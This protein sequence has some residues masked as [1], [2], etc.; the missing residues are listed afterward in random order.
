[1]SKVSKKRKKANELVAP[2]KFYLLD[3]ACSVVKEANTTKFD[4][5]VD[6]HV[7]LGV[8]PRKPDQAIRGTVTL[9]NG[10]EAEVLTEILNSK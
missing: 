5:S 1:M 9:P 4:A 10:T 8:D 3:E 2:T 6:L 7:R